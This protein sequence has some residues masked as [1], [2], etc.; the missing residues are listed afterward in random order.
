MGSKTENTGDPRKK[1]TE[2]K[3]GACADLSR[4]S[5]QSGRELRPGPPSLEKL[6]TSYSCLATSHLGGALPVSACLLTASQFVPGLAS[7]SLTRRGGRDGS[8]RIK[9]LKSEENPPGNARAK[10]RGERRQEGPFLDSCRTEGLRRVTVFPPPETSYDHRRHRVQIISSVVCSLCL[11]MYVLGCA[12][13]ER[14][15]RTRREKRAE[16]VPGDGEEEQEEGKTL[17][18]QERQERKEAEVLRRETPKCNDASPAVIP[19]SS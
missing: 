13:P 5:S 3:D 10:A 18:A 1:N 17:R 4:S 7:L 16:A 8:G 11:C 14:L 6:S 12:C 15:G 2:G 19:T 9:R